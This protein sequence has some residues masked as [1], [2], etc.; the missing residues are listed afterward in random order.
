MGNGRSV[1][2]ARVSRD[3]LLAT[4]RPRAGPRLSSRRRNERRE[5][6]DLRKDRASTW[7]SEAV[8]LCGRRPGRCA[9]VWTG[10]Q[11]EW[12]TQDAAWAPGRRRLGHVVVGWHSPGHQAVVWEGRIGEERTGPPLAAGCAESGQ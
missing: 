9:G 11:H 10:S 3:M 1:R 12:L 6:H 7:A 2:A 5:F 4:L 8:T